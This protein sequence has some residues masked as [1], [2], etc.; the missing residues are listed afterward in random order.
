MR[1]ARFE[2]LMRT[3]A[4]GSL[5]VA[6]LM[7]AGR[8][9]LSAQN[10]TQRYCNPLPIPAYPIQTASG[11]DMRSMADPTVIRAGGKWYLYPSNGLAWWSSDLVNW[12]YQ[13]MTLPGVKGV[14]WAPTVME[15]NGSFYLTANGLGLYGAEDPLGPW[16]LLGDFRDEE[17]KVYQPFDPMLFRD[18]DGRVYFYFAGGAATGI[19]GVELDPKD[20]TRFLGKRRHLFAYEP[21]H[22]WESAGDLNELTETS[23]IEGPW[24][25]RQGG[26]YYLQYSAPGTEWKTYA[27]GL[28][29][30]ESPLGPFRYDPRSPLLVDRKGLLNGSAH[31]SVVEGP[32]GTHWVIYHV[33]YR[34]RYRFERRLAMDPVGF[35]E[36]G[37][38]IMRGPSETPQWAPG[39]K[40]KPWVDNDSGSIVLSLNKP[41]Q[42]SSSYSGRAPE[43][44]VDNNARTWWQAADG[45]KG[46]YLEI[47]LMQDFTVDSTRILWSDEGLDLKKG[48]RPAPYQYTISV[49]P[50]GK[51]Y[52]TVVDK[53]KN[54][55]DMNI[56]FDE[57]PP[58]R[59]RR[60]R[61][62]ISGVPAGMPVGVLELTVFGK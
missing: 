22:K 16:Q 17:G 51:S 18:G 9:A 41:V 7:S 1:K 43:Y 50:D 10:K 35:D 6:L 28:Y 37:R 34:N 21:A 14:V 57:I 32:N 20:L 11:R 38:M 40:A 39:V 4:V 26:R 54:T 8:G 47:D 5:A 13:P 3:L 46:P 2:V 44:G 31:H 56:Q 62:T 59:A 19:F 27:V 45:D 60:V 52:S 30:G 23:W 55:E 24:M 49:S 61:L 58:V 36:Q 29:E 15:H 42:S 25:T 53:M 12:H 33:L 48:V